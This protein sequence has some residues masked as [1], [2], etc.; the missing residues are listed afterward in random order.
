MEYWVERNK[1]IK[2]D[3]S[4]FESYDSIIPPFHYSMGAAKSISLNKYV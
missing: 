4:A 1:K 2:Y 3:F